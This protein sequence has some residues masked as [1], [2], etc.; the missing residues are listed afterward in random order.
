M[1]ACYCL[2]CK[3]K[4]GDVDPQ[5]YVLTTTKGSRY[6]LKSKC[7]KCGRVKCKFISAKEAHGSGFIGDLIKKVAPGTAGTIDKVQGVLGS[8]P[9]LGPLANMLV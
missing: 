2:K 4:T 7:E 5:V 9:L 8:I 6:Q 1:S 3:E